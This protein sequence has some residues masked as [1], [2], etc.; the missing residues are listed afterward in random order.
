MGG[1]GWLDARLDCTSSVCPSWVEQRVGAHSSSGVCRWQVGEFPW[2]VCFLRAH[3]T[4]H[5]ERCWSHRTLSS[6][7]PPGCPAV[8]ALGASEPLWADDTKRPITGKIRTP[9][10]QIP[11]LQSV[12]NFGIQN[13]KTGTLSIQIWMQW[14]YNTVCKFLRL[15]GC[16]ETKLKS[17]C[18]L[19]QF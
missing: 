18:F 19:A 2:L 12:F 1:L 17:T 13:V 6:N 11:L 7:G 16:S 4:D 9:P 5:G 14:A 8:W 15:R 10:F 3:R